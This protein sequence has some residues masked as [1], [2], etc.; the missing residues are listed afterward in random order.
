MLKNELNISIAI[1]KKEYAKP[2]RWGF[3]TRWF[4][5][6]LVIDILFFCVETDTFGY[7]KYYL[8]YWMGGEEEDHGAHH[9]TTATQNFENHFENTVLPNFS[10]STLNIGQILNLNDTKTAAWVWLFVDGSFALI[11]VWEYFFRICRTK[12]KWFQKGVALVLMVA[13]V[14]QVVGPVIVGQ[15]STL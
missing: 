15:L 3:S 12:W 4:V 6:V 2:V 7:S 11:Y 14:V 8:D 9:D 10:P 5:L 13:A 1:A